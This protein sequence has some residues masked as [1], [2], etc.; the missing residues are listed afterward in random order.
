M[1]LAETYDFPRSLLVNQVEH[2]VGGDV[3]Q[4][5][6]QLGVRLQALLGVDDVVGQGAFYYPVG[7]FSRSASALETSGTPAVPAKKDRRR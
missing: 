7:F 2:Q 5:E 1:L 6:G 4:G 3:A